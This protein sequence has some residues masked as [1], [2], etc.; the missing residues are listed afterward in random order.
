MGKLLAG[1]ENGEGN[2]NVMRT[3]VQVEFQSYQDSRPEEYYD[4]ILLGKR[5]RLTVYEAKELVQKLILTMV[6][7]GDASTVLGYFKVKQ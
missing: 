2:A 5:N 4:V 7:M 6:E 1:L 3:A